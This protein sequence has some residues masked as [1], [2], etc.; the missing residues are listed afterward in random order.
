MT[1][2]ARLVIG[3]DGPRSFVARNVQ[4]PAYHV[5]P[6]LTCNYYSYW[7][8]IPIEGVELYPRDHRFIIA[9]PTNAGLTYVGVI[10]PRQEFHTVRQDIASSH[11]QALEQYVPELAVRVHQGQREER[12]IGTADLPFFFRKPYGPGWALVGDA[13]YHLDPITAQGMTDAF[14][15]AELL[16]A[17][18]DAGFSGRQR[19]EE[20]L[21]NYELVR[22]EASLPLYNYSYQLATLEL[23]SPEMQALFAALQ[24][25]QAETDR[26]FGVLAGTV[27]LA[28]FFNPERMQQVLEA[29]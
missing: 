8:G 9:M 27:P 6:T 18:C 10:W 23:P 29:V 13:G 26:F 21:A 11:M 15:D 1:E 17:A 2:H 4:A 19:I 16:A 22:N 14:R 12:F 7:S 24:G 5:K 28:K 3:A 25:N 20:A